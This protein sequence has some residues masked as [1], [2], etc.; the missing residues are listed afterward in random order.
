M[1]VRTNRIV[2]KKGILGRRLKARFQDRK[3]CFRTV[4]VRRKKIKRKR[5]G[6]F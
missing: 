5:R 4:E 2:V 3:F 6:G 1:F